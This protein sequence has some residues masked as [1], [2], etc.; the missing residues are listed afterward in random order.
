MLLDYEYQDKMYS[1]GI[2]LYIRIF[3]NL[4]YTEQQ[5]LAKKNTT[6]YK[7]KIE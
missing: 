3:N 2:K 6:N 1:A 7:Y 4:Q 5:L